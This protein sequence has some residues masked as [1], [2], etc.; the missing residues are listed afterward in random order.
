ME[1]R[2]G[3]LAVGARFDTLLTG[4]RGVVRANRVWVDSST[5]DTVVEF[6][7]GVLKGLHP[8]VVVRVVEAVH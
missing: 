7:G 6:V 3:T 2:V 4:R 1:A 5:V 8:D